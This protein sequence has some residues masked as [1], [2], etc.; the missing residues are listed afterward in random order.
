VIKIVPSQGGSALRAESVGPHVLR[1]PDLDTGE[2]TAPR[3]PLALRPEDSDH[4]GSPNV[5]T[6]LMVCRYALGTS[7]PALSRAPSALHRF[8]ACRTPLGNNLREAVRSIANACEELS[9][10]NR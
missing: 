5:V 3:E 4:T 9:W 7:V 2:L 1:W 10:I 6:H 8:S